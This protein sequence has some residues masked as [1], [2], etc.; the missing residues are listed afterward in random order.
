MA[1][2]IQFLYY[3]EFM[4]YKKI[5]TEKHFFFQFVDYFTNYH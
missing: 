4:Y 5:M 3:D 2:L 1:Y